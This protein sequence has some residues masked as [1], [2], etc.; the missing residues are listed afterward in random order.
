MLSIAIVLKISLITMDKLEI[1]ATAA[2]PGRRSAT[3]VNWLG[4]NFL[5]KKELNT[6]AKDLARANRILSDAISLCGSIVKLDTVREIM[7][8]PEEHQEEVKYLAE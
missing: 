1:D 3:W 2:A 5:Q 6:I 4:V 8:N 7:R